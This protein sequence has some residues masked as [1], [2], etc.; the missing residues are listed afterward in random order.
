MAG[1]VALTFTLI[2]VSGALVGATVSKAGSGAP[3]KI[4]SCPRGA[5]ALSPQDLK[6]AQRVVFRYAAGKWARKAE[7]RI[8]G[9]HVTGV[10]MASRWLKGGFVKKTCGTT[11]WMRTVVVSVLYP[12]E[13]YAHGADPGPCNSCAGADFLASRTRQGWLI[14]YVL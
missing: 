4:G 3:P 5:L 7:M 6:D 2:A 13:F 9:A 14:W 12:A 8:R 1:R 11:T 10:H